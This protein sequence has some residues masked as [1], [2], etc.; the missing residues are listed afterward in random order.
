QAFAVWGKNEGNHMALTRE[1]RSRFAGE[2]LGRGPQW[3]DFPE[4]NGFVAGSRRQAR[5]VRRKGDAS[6]TG[7]VAV[8]ERFSGGHVNQ[9]Q[10][11]RA[12]GTG[13]GFPVRG[14]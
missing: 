13:D 9:A 12:I 11:I 10:P 1:N 4:G 8:E 6:P 2:G 14:K 5:T 7:D 3:G